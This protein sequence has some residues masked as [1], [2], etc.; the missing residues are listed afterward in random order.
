MTFGVDCTE[1][2]P[3]AHLP[4]SS[5]LSRRYLGPGFSPRQLRRVIDSAEAITIRLLGCELSLES[6]IAQEYIPSRLVADSSGGFQRTFL[7]PGQGAGQD[8]DN[9][10][11]RSELFKRR[12]ESC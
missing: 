4:V 5:W 11:A 7:F 1:S 12:G 2:D 10:N 3:G 9:P 8:S 6:P